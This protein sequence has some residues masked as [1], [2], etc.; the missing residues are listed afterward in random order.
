MSQFAKMLTSPPPKG[1]SSSFNIIPAQSG[2]MT[3]KGGKTNP[4]SHTSPNVQR[5][6]KTSPFHVP[7]D[8]EVFL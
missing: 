7:N 6:A 8:E 2:A 5:M 1:Q 4:Y 3:A